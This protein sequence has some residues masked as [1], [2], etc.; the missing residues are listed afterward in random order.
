MSADAVGP[1]VRDLTDE[2]HRLEV[3]IAQA[4]GEHPGAV[5]AGADSADAAEAL[6]RELPLL[7]RREVVKA[8][9]TV[10]I[11]PVGKGVRW[12]DEE[13]ARHVQIVWR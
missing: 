2:L 6:W 12:K 1:R 3:E 13:A 10:R 4:L 5:L 9:M 8:L 7:D 11:L